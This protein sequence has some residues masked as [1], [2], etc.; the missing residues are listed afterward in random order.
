MSK[1]MIRS[2]A[3]SVFMLMVMLAFAGCGGAANDKTENVGN[4]TAA[5]TNAEQTASSTGSGEKITMKFGSGCA[6]K[7]V[8][9]SLVDKYNEKMRICFSGVQIYAKI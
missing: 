2:V 4:E 7:S 5:A 3:L 8:T 6:R 1:R 9:S